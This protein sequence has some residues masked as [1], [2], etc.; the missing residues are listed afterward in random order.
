MLVI[1]DWMISVGGSRFHET[2]ECGFHMKP[3]VPSVPLG[4]VAGS[5]AGEFEQDTGGVKLAIPVEPL[6]LDGGAAH[7]CVGRDEAVI[8][9]SPLSPQSSG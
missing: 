3:G 7:L 8:A 2:L 1:D 6:R 4:G 5:P 9:R